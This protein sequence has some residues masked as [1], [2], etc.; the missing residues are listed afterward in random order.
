VLK[1]RARLAVAEGAGEEE[2]KV[3]EQIVEL[4][5]LDGEALLLLGRHSDRNG[6]SEQAIFYYERAASLE[7]FEADAKVAHAQLLVRQGKYRD[8]IP[9]LERAQML[10]PRE[11]VQEYLEQVE[12]AA[13]SR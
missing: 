5:P 3:L 6:D 11:N 2:V 4:D 1:L 9:M 13:K 10:E 12:R 8:A 7:A